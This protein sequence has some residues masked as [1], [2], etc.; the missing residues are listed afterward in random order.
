L[1]KRITDTIPKVDKATYLFETIGWVQDGS[2]FE[3][4]RKSLIELRLEIDRENIVDQRRGASSSRQ[5]NVRRSD[6]TFWSNARESLRELIRLGLMQHG[7][8]PSR[9]AQLR[10]HRGQTFTL[11]EDGEHFLALAEANPTEFRHRFVQAMEIAHPYLRALRAELMRK[12]FFFPRIQKSDV[13]GDPTLWQKG[14]PE[15]FNELASKISEQV[16]EV[17]GVAIA[18][19]SLERKMRP[20]LQAAWKR[21]NQQ[22][23]PKL[24]SKWV[25]KTLNDTVV[26]VLLGVYVV[27]MDFVTFRS[28]VSLLT[29]LDAIWGTR[30]LLGRKGWTIWSTSDGAPV[31][32]AIQGLSPAAQA[33]HGDVWF[34]PHKVSDDILRDKIV[35]AFFSLKDRSGG[36]AL[37]H[38]LRAEVCHNLRIHGSRFNSVLTKMHSRELVHGRYAVNL[39]RG[40]GSSLPPSEE[41]FRIG[42]RAFYLITF[43]ERS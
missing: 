41:P 13:P 5:L 8:L 10:V 15:T 9:A 32:E 18:P 23:N 3:E 43:F 30:S 2:T 26:R 34:N 19:E 40:G 29:D 33:L 21:R 14:P 28:A 7:R 22:L 11:T 35:D 38:V 39:D 24:L 16:R 27:Q 25:V 17:M 36:I 12:E 37:I 4:I 31:S 42:D 1:T 20:Y 6:S